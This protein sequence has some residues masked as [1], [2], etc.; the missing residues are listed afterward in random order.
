MELVLT[1]TSVTKTMSLES[2]TEDLSHT[3]TFTYASNAIE[4]KVIYIYNACTA[5]SW[6]QNED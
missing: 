3:D 1:Y 2:Y 4:V 5:H 6:N